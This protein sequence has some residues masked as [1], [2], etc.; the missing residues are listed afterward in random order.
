MKITAQSLTTKLATDI[1]GVK[2]KLLS[3][4]DAVKYQSEDVVEGKKFTVS[5]PDIG[6]VDVKVK[7]DNFD[8]IA[9]SQYLKFTEVRAGLIGNN[10]GVYLWI[11]AEDVV[12]A[13]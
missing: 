13:K 2:A 6:T 7:K 4:K 12:P 5:V 1:E 8:D 3:S 9:G 11:L 10:S